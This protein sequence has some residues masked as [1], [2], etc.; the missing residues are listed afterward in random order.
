MDACKFGCFVADRRK[1]LNMSQKDL[2]AKLQVTDKAISKWERGLGFPDINSLE[3]LADALDVS[4]TELMKS[5]KISQTSLTKETDDIVKNVVN[6]ASIDAEEK[7]KI[8]AY[9]FAG[10]TFILA[11]LEI[12]LTL[13]WDNETASL[14]ATIPYIAVIPG[15]LMIVWGI[16]S[17][18]KGKQTNGIWAL[19]IS[20]LLVPVILYCGAFLVLSM[21]H[22]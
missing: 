1:E 8:I 19:G 15:L 13:K 17:K 14:S 5:E 2:A 6:V 22:S 12:L 9:T 7:R 3:P 11:F 20:L 4:I 21:I 10:T 18:V 16:V